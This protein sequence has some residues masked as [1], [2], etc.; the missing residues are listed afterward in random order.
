MSLL[1]RLKSF[2]GSEEE[3]DR[4][5]ALAEIRR[6]YQAAVHREQQLRAQAEEAPHAAGR[7]GLR[8]LA[9]DEKQVVEGLR[10]VI[11]QLGSFAGEVVSAPAPHGA[12]NYW[13]RLTQALEDH[14][15]AVGSLIDES[16]LL[17]DGQP[18]IADQL[19]EMARA[20]I[21]LCGNLRALIAKSDPQAL[22]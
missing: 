13:G 21:A 8:A 2:F 9:A 11:Q 19:R 3:R 17:T 14:K 20:E 22:N 5:D 18:E 1:R 12:L 6:F 7:D 4:H 16:V 10:R 15:E